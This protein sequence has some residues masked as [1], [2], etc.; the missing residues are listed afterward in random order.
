MTDRYWWNVERVWKSWLTSATVC[1]SRWGTRSNQTCPVRVHSPMTS[2]PSTSQWFYRFPSIFFFDVNSAH[3]HTHTQKLGKNP[4]Q[5]ERRHIGCTCRNAETHLHSF[6][7]QNPTQP[8]Y[9]VFCAFGRCGGF[10]AGKLGWRPFIDRAASRRRGMRN[11]PPR[12]L[13]RRSGVGLFRADAGSA[14]PTT[15]PRP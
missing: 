14:R 12:Q 2:S 11:P 7:T 13:R 9:L 5:P 8:T 1:K 4:V 15:R 3:T 10:P 6:A